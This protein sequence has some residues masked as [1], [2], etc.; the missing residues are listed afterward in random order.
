MYG[1][2]TSRAS[3]AQALYVTLE[4]S[5]GALTVELYTAHA[6]R[7]ARGCD[8]IQIES[9][10]HQAPNKPVDIGRL[11]HYHGAATAR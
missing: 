6:P 3:A 9:E 1:I 8:C 5:L 10:R 4:T 7:Y 2:N 11:Q